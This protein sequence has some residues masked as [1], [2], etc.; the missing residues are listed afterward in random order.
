[1]PGSS[2]DVEGESDTA[3]S[4][5]GAFFRLFAGVAEAAVAVL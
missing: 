2:S 5:L 1:M 4:L 3:G